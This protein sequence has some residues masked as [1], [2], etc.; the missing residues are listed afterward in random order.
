MMLSGKCVCTVCKEFWSLY[1][2]INSSSICLDVYFTFF[3][4]STILSLLITFIT[5]SSSFLFLYSRSLG[6]GGCMHKLLYHAV[7]FLICY[8]KIQS[9][10]CSLLLVTLNLKKQIIN[11]SFEP[12]YNMNHACTYLYRDQFYHLF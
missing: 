8:C 6:G 7:S 2:E 12:W 4:I 9:C 1:L 11:I 5:I 10:M 3:H